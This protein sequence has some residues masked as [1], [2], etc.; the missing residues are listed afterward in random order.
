MRGLIVAGVVLLAVI[1]GVVV[2]GLLL[3]RAHRVTSRLTLPVPPDSVWAVVR[4][5]GQ[6]PSWWTDVKAVERVEQPDGKERWGETM[7]G[8]MRL[9][10]RIEDA[11]PPRR[12]RSVIED[13]GEPFGGEWIYQVSP[14]A[15]GS[16]IDITEDGWVSNPVFRVVSRAMGHHRT[17]DS[18]L[19]ALA[20]RLGAPAAIEHVP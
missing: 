15:G 20:R 18:Y 1:V 14:A 7:G 11:E 8:D 17:I 9:L 5:I 19:S 12:M 13:T 6:L 10:L 3:P 16:S 2:T 4:D